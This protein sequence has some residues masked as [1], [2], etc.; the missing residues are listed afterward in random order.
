MSL[1][2]F[3]SLLLLV[4][5]SSVAYGEGQL[6][7]NWYGSTFPACME[8]SGGWGWEKDQTC[9]SDK[10][11]NSAWGGPS[12]SCD[13]YGTSIPTCSNVSTGWG[14]ENNATCISEQ[15][16]TGVEKSTT[17]VSPMGN[18][19][20]WGTDGNSEAASYADFIST[21]VGYEYTQGREGDCDGCRLVSTLASDADTYAVFYGY[22]IGYALPDCNV[23]PEGGNLCTH[24]AQWIRD[25][26]QKI[27]KLYGDYAAKAYAADPN[28]G[29]FWLLEGDFH[30]YT[31]ENQTNPLSLQEL[32]QLASDIIDAIKKNAPN[33]KVAI[34][35]STWLSDDATRAMW[36]AM[37]LNKTDF[38][39]TT[40]DGNNA[41]GYFHNSTTSTTYN[42]ATAKYGFL[43][44]FTGKKLFVDTS[45][46]LS[47]GDDTWSGASEELLNKRIS[48][49]VFA[50]NV[51]K[52]SSG[53]EERVK[54]LR[55]LLNDLS[56]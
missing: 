37:P 11:C 47:Q 33:A 19:L 28:K 41:E 21:W 39:W 53:Y 17:P 32:G 29:V 16:C 42:A 44:N 43:S 10:M 2:R 12:K 49:G 45:F 9:I 13:W 35:H 30:Q 3:L 23:Q 24:G 55:L 34:N 27:L 52:P 56:Q 18:E 54:I 5:T 22:F 7:C 46:G 36:S 15:E 14:W 51:T 4:V 6:Y 48:E 26:R 38:I 31:V 8:K 20:A 25:N 40:G 1:Y 50:V